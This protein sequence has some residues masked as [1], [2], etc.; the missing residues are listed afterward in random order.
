LRGIAI[1][2]ALSVRVSV[3]VRAEC[4]SERAEC[5]SERC[6]IYVDTFGKHLSGYIL[7]IQVRVHTYNIS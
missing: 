4:E 7:F 1:T 2:Y 3:V 6:S 5:E